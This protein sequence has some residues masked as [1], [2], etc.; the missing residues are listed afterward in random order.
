MIISKEEYLDRLKQKAEQA[1]KLFD[2]T[3]SHRQFIEQ[4]EA[5]Q[6]NKSLDGRQQCISRMQSIDRGLAEL[7]PETEGYK[8]D[9]EIAALYEHINSLIRQTIEMDEANHKLGSGKMKGYK[10]DIRQNRETRKGLDAYMG[11]TAEA[12]G[13]DQKR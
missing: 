4:D 6:L 12:A 10:A 1:E 2:M 5:V 11:Y 7:E 3:A 13:F 9:G 8:K